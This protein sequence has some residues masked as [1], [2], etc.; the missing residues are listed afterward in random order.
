MTFSTAADILSGMR[1]TSESIL[2]CFDADGQM[3]AQRCL[4]VMTDDEDDVDVMVEDSLHNDDNPQHDDAM[5]MTWLW[6]L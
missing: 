1:D 4:D 2:D 5:T 6:R 3:D